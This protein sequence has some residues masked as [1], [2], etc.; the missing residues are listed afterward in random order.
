[1]NNLAISIFLILLAIFL[2]YTIGSVNFAKLL[3]KWLKVDL[4]KGSSNPGATNLARLSKLRYGILVAFGDLLKI[5]VAGWFSYLI[6]IA[7]ARLTNQ[8]LNNVGPDINKL[9]HYIIVITIYLCPTLAVVGHC[10]PVQKKFHT[11]GKGVASFVG[12][13][14]FIS[15]WIGLITMGLWILFAISSK[16]I[17]LSSILIA[18]IAPWLVGV[19]FLTNYYWIFSVS[20]NFYLHF[21]KFSHIK[22]GA[23]NLFLQLMSFFTLWLVGIMVVIRHKNNIVKLLTK[24]EQKFRVKF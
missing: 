22:F 17:S 14:F 23:N 11:G 3:A 15:P 8:F 13:T 19:S 7:G 1:M 18:I 10:F 4:T 24:Q 16:Y 12:L 21:N 20:P 6:L 2:G 9:F 5:M